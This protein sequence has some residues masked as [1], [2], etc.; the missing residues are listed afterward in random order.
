MRIYIKRFLL[1]SFL[2]ILSLLSIGYPSKAAELPKKPTSEIYFQDYAGMFS[3]GT[4]NY[5]LNASE[6][7]KN[8]TTAE[9]AVVTINSLD[10]DSIQNYANNLFRSWGIGNKEKNTGVLVLISKDD[11]D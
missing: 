1:S 4:K 10:G 2:I 9:V 11:M 3:S 6:D 8:K 5:I 7:V